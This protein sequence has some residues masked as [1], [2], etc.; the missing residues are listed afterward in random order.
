MIIKKT[1][2][3]TNTFVDTLIETL[4]R[5]S[6]TVNFQRFV[7]IINNSEYF[8]RG[9]V[10]IFD[11]QEGMSVGG[12]SFAGGAHVKVSANHTFVSDANDRGCKTFITSNMSVDNLRV[13]LRYFFFLSWLFNFFGFN[14]NFLSFRGLSNFALADNL[15]LDL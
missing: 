6:F 4:K 7:R 2:E 11:L 3:C 9:L 5:N 10:R 14:L 13:N 15:L 8:E 12:F 1:S